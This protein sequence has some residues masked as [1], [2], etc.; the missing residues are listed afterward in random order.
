MHVDHR[1][2]P[3]FRRPELCLRNRLAVYRAEP[4]FMLQASRLRRRAV[5]HEHRRSVHDGSE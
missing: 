1:A 3:M 2:G 4:A 5:D